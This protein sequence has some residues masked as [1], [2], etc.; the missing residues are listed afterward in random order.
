MRNIQYLTALIAVTML[1]ACQPQNNSTDQE[2]Q[3]GIKADD[4]VTLSTSAFGCESEMDFMNAIKHYGNKEYAAWADDVADKIRCFHG[5][6][7]DKK[8]LEWTVFQVQGDVVQVG[9]MTAAQVAQDSDRY[10]HKYW[11]MTKWVVPT[12]RD[13]YEGMK[14]PDAESKK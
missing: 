6:G 1:V 5:G 3:H 2:I 9:F 10:P 8:T 13:I 12:G 14:K 7:S 4:I 11:T